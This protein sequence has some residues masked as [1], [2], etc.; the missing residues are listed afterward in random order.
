[1]RTGF[2]LAGQAKVASYS[3][4]VSGETPQTWA[5]QTKSG[6]AGSLSTV[7]FEVV[8]CT[9]FVFEPFMGSLIQLPEMKVQQA[10]SS[11]FFLPQSPALRE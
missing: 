3:L 9:E 1:M 4:M 8:R 5:G 2:E 6:Q 11:E 10:Q 7:P